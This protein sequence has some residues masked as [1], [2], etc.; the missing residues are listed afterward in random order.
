MLKAVRRFKWSS[1]PENLA[2]SQTGP[3][4]QMEMF[5]ACFVYLFIQAGDEANRHAYGTCQDAAGVQARCWKLH[6]AEFSGE[7]VRST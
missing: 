5:P 1:S 4:K 6:F 7:I 3:P 2:A